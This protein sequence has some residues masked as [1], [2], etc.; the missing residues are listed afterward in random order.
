MFKNL[1]SISSIIIKNITDLQTELISEC[2]ILR[3]SRLIKYLQ[4]LADVISTLETK[5]QD[6]YREIKDAILNICELNRISIKELFDKI[7][8]KCNNCIS[9][10]KNNFEFRFIF[11]QYFSP[12]TI[13]PNYLEAP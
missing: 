4:N 13:N 11:N 6:F 8:I 2:P 3:N 5:P 10:D 9:K 1:D 12:K 7:E